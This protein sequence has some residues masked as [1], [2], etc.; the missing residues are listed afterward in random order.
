M[1]PECFGKKLDCLDIHCEY[2]EFCTI[3]CASLVY[4]DEEDED[5]DE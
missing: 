2:F 3:K 1:E 4:D 5:E